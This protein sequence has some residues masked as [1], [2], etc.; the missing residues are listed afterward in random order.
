MLTNELTQRLPSEFVGQLPAGIP[1][2]F[3]AIPL[4]NELAEPIRTT[5]RN[6]FADSIRT[7]W[8][9]LIPFGAVGLFAASFMKHVALETV[10]DAAWGLEHPKTKGDPEKAVVAGQD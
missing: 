6:A 1:S 5:V 9:V 10:T 8:L 7:I 3:A 4:I 2:A